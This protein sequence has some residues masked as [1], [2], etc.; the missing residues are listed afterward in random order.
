MGSTGKGGRG[1][2]AATHYVHG[3][4]IAGELGGG[5]GEGRGAATHYVHGVLIAG[6]LGGVRG[7]G[8]RMKG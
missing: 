1:G 4:L 8:V 2:G 3:V 6:E 5:G 7:G